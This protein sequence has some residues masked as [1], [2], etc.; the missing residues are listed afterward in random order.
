MQHRLMIRGRPHWI[1]VYQAEPDM[2]CAFGEA[3]GKP[4][5]AFGK[6]ETAAI[7]TWREIATG[8]PKA[9]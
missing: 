3:K 7:E 5:T 9:R 1:T 4:L 6:T 2:W 8:R